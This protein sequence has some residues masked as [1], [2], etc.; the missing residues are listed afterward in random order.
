MAVWFSARTDSVLSAQHPCSWFKQTHHQY[1]I[2]AASTKVRV[3]QKRPT[4]VPASRARVGRY[5][6]SAPRIA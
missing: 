6:M 2:R 1:R 4:I 3:V 5:P